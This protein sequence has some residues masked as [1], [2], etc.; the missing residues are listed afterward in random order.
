MVRKNENKEK[1][2]NMSKNNEPCVPQIHK[3]EDAESVDVPA[4]SDSPM[5]VG[6]P[7]I[8]RNNI[9]N[10]EDPEIQPL[11]SVGSV[12]VVSG[13]GIGMSYPMYDDGTWDEEMGCHLEDIES[14]EW[15]EALDRK[16]SLLVKQI[17][18]KLK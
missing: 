3:Y 18:G 7:P 2:K 6:Q 10:S 11:Y 15:F 4:D 12:L 5:I 13:D 16:D 14:V 8:D 17:K 1:E 9:Q